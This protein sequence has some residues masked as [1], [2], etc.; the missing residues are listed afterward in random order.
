M[1][2]FHIRFPR[3]RAMGMALS[4]G[5]LGF[6]TLT[7]CSDKADRGG[8]GAE[9]V[10]VSAAAAVRR[11]VPVQIKAVGH[12][13]AS[14]TVTVKSRVDGMLEHVH[15][16]E[17]STVGEGA[18]LFEIDARPYK[19]ALAEAE[20]HLDR[21]RALA[22]K[23]AED[24]RRYAELVKKQYITQ[25][26]YDAIQASAQSLEATVRADEAAVDGA[27]LNL[28]FCAIRSPLA[29]RAGDLLV[30]EGN[31]VMAADARG[32]VV[33]NRLR[34]VFVAFS[35]PEQDLARIRRAMAAGPVPVEITPPEG[36]PPSAGSLKFLD[37]T[38]DPATGS[39]QI[40]AVLPNEDERL[41]P[42]QF[43]TVTLT[44]STLPGA[45]VVPAQAVQAG[46]QGTFVYVVK[47]DRTVEFRPVKPGIGLDGFLVIEQG[48]A[49]GETVVTNGHL[50]LTPGAKVAVTEETPAP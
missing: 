40:K 18:L 23:A 24:S 16:R 13:E 41:W 38:V 47:A 32:L 17:G 33:I 10:P 19:A 48:V 4:L 9:T 6:L 27:R 22:R 26:Q 5:A 8:K 25:E 21:D 45:V 30:R 43:V 1:T 3:Y 49:A 7:A 12:V 36:G 14:T 31:L 35:V 37:N 50:R 15:I 29:G 46:Q 44:L 28:E 34:P 20:A 42:G 2:L 11:D 39:I